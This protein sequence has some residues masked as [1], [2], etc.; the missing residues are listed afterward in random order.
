[1]M[2]RTFGTAFKYVYVWAVKQS[3][4]ILLVGS[5]N[6]F[7]YNSEEIIRRVEVLNKSGFPLDFVLSKDPEQTRDFLK[8]A[9]GIPFNTDDKPLLEFRVARNLLTGVVQ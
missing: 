7:A 4:D 8:N 3:L 5:N 2:V 6:P 9:T 1:M